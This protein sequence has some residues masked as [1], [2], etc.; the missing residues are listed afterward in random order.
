MVRAAWVSLL[1][2]WAL[3]GGMP[4][5]AQSGTALELSIDGAIG[6]ATAD[7]VERGLARARESAA[8]VVVLRI[9]TPGGLDTSMRQI[10]RAILASPVP[11]IG[12]VAPEGS[13]AASAGTYILYACALA[14][15]A[16]ATNLGAA[17]PVQLGGGQS[18]NDTLT[19]KQVNDAAAFIRSLAERNGR[20]V[21][22]AEQAVR[23]AVSLSAGEAQRKGVINFIAD[24]VPAVLAAAD[25]RSVRIGDEKRVLHTQGL[26]VERLAPDWRSQ[27]LSFIAD[28]NVAYILLLIGIYGLIFEL[29][30]PG[31]LLPGV[32]GAI[33]LVLGLYALQV[34]PINYAGLALMGLGVAFMIGEVFV[35]S[36]GALG[37]GGVLAFT[38]GSIILFD[39]A[40]LS[41][42]LTLVGGT[43][44]VSAAFFLWVISRLLGLRRRRPVSGREEMVGSVGVV[45]SLSGDHAVIR[46]HGESWNAIADQPLHTG[47]RVRITAIDGLKLTVTPEE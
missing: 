10:A 44:A 15:M 28:P 12:Y 36:F 43:A 21:A 45:A 31:Y 14:A 1:L 35:P 37:L 26:T 34:L 11:V 8:K 19:H 46:V 17:T 29:A 20:N 13:R 47:Q 42:S 41:V 23:E 2:V 4:A 32:A 3:L 24:S 18:K 27:L 5:H 7:Y 6:P 39:S 33:C 9:N 38:V 30:S 22:W 40:D 25:G 16:P